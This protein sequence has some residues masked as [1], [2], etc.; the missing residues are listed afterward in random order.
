MPRDPHLHTGENG[1]SATRLWIAGAA[2]ATVLGVAYAA[3]AVG[4]HV[5]RD[6]PPDIARTLALQLVPW[7]AWAFL[8]PAVYRFCAR[9]PL[10]GG[11]ARRNA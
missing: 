7:Y 5:A 2:A 1:P 10:T 3:Q 4:L 8:L 9:W 11:G 6:Q